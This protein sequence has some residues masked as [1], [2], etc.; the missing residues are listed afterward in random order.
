MNQISEK[1]NRVLQLESDLSSLQV[2]MHKLK[3]DLTERDSQLRLTRMNLE[4]A[5]KQGQVQEEELER[6]QENLTQLQSDLDLKEE[7]LQSYKTEVGILCGLYAHLPCSLYQ[8][9]S[10]NYR[11]IQFYGKWCW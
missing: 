2:K 9:L 5:K 1:D 4:T 8:T 7:S 10:T 11:R 6:T 3:D